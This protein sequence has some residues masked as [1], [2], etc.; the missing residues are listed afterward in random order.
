MKTNTIDFSVALKN[1]LRETYDINLTVS[2][3]Y[4]VNSVGDKLKTETILVF[5]RE[6]KYAP[7]L[8]IRPE[9]TEEEIYKFVNKQLKKKG[10]I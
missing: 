6:E 4:T 5:D 8:W 1:Y 2:N 3:G 7:Y 10:K 9:T